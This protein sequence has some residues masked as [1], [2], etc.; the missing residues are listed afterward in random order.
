MK[1][2]IIL[3]IALLLFLTDL[4]LTARPSIGRIIQLTGDV[5]LTEID[6]GI[7]IIASIGTRIKT[8]QRIRT[9]QKSYVE[10]LLYD[11]TKIFLREL[12]IL[13]I[14][15]IRNKKQNTPTEIKFHLGK[16]RINIDKELPGRNLILK[17]KYSLY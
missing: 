14:T 15:N 11:N 5:D 9:G 13:Q 3:L 10:I 4:N 8:T 6:S 1:K 16:I 12:S 2:N 7:R 17:T